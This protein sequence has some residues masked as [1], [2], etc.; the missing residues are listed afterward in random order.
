MPQKLCR[1]LFHVVV[2]TNDRRNYIP[3]DMLENVWKQVFEIA[4][5]HE[6][7]LL[8]VGGTENHVHLLLE[9]PPEMSVA[10]A[11]RLIK[12]DTGRWLRESVRLFA[13]QD[14]YLAFSVSPSQ[15]K[16]VVKY[17]SYQPEHHR[18]C[19]VEEELSTLLIGAGLRSESARRL[20][21]RRQIVQKN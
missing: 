12:T 19:S 15:I 7:N 16:R 13:W 10:Q 6:L 18:T 11:V 9:I 3:T 5:R 17:I 21:Q 4:R 14:D 2:T 1:T 20:R 8:A